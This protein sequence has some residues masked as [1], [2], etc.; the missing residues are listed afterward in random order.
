MNR[1]VE[2]FEDDSTRRLSSVRAGTTWVIV[3][4]TGVLLW[5][6]RSAVICQAVVPARSDCFSAVLSLSDTL[7]LLGSGLYL[8]VRAKGVVEAWAQKPG[9]VNVNQKDSASTTVN[10]KD[11]DS[12]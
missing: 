7:A 11:G 6:T 9:D 3:I 1:W 2:L 10:T 8:L 4:L 12:E 5:I